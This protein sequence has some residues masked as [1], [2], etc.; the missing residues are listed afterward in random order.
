WIPIGTYSTNLQTSAFQG[1][2]DGN[3]KKIKNLTYNNTLDTGKN[4][5]L[6]G[7]IYNATITNLILENFNVTAYQ[8]AGALSGA[9]QNSTIEKVKVINSFVRVEYN[10]SGYGGGL[11]GDASDGTK[12]RECVVLDST[13]SGAK[14]AVGGLLGQL[15]GTTTAPVLVENCYVKGG[16]V[17]SDYTS[18]TSASGFICNYN[19][20]TSGG[21]VKNNYAAIKVTN[22]QG[23]VGY[24]PTS[25]N[26]KGASNN[27]FD[28][29]VATTDQDKLL[30]NGVTPKTTTEMKQRSTYQGWNFDSVWNIDDGNDYPYLRWEYTN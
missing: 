28:K 17:K 7:Y 26:N 19:I 12:I 23:F 3:G 9:S 2:F 13:I 29:D 24:L 20:P 1:V 27:Y 22:G 15:K 25:T 21:E 11:I 18:S 5:G 16:E 4:V 14:Y 30:N 6:F 10:G 8:R